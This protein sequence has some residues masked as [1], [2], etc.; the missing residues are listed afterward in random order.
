MDA[1]RRLTITSRWCGHA[2]LLL[3]ESGGNVAVREEA[4]RCGGLLLKQLAAGVANGYCKRVKVIDVVA[5][6]WTTESDSLLFVEGGCDRAAF[7]LAGLRRN[8]VCPLAQPWR[9]TNFVGDAVGRSHRND[10]EI[11]QLCL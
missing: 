3:A 5:I 2:G 4:V 11:T 1:D 7:H 10:T 9:T 8:F 6:V